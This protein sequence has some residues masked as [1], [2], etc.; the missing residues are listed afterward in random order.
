M[1]TM[2]LA[3]TDALVLSLRAVHL[4]P[5]PLGLERRE[6]ALHDVI[7]LG[8]AGSTHRADNPIVGY[9]SLELL[10]GMLT[11]LTRVMQQGV[12]LAARQ[13]AII[14]A[15]VTSR[16]VMC[17]HLRSSAL[18]DQPPLCMRTGR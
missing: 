13:I 11:A 14:S 7:I 12:G 18:I 3:L 16:A 6:E 1:I 2:A 5:D 8:I 17:A 10:T 15:L 9:Q 4:L